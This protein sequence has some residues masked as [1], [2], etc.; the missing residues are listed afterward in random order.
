MPTLVVKSVGSKWLQ[1]WPSCSRLKSTSPDRTV[2]SRCTNGALSCR[3]TSCQPRARKARAI[4]VFSAKK[5]SPLLSWSW[6]EA[7]SG[8]VPHP[9]HSTCRC[10]LPGAPPR[11]T[12]CKTE[13]PRAPA[14]VGLVQ[15]ERSSHSMSAH[16]ASPPPSLVSGRTERCR[17][18][19][20]IDRGLPAPSTSQTL[21]GP[22]GRS[23]TMQPVCIVARKEWGGPAASCSASLQASSL[24]VL[25]LTP[26]WHVPTAPS[27]RR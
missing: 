14:A 2:Q 13:A 17:G 1:S 25:S 16:D 8:A 3:S 19:S 5:R 4:P 6:M 12:A 11:T 18:T 20:P 21:T 27:S 22:K 10:T 24:P 15:R 23:R 26:T 9:A 7:T